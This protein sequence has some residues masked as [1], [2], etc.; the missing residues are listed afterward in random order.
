MTG[1]AALAPGTTEAPATS[2]ALAANEGGPAA[3]QPTYT[4][5]ATAIF[6]K[7]SGPAVW[8]ID[9]GG[10][11]LQLR[12]VKVN[13]YTDHKTVITAGL[14]DGDVVVLAG[15]HTVYVGQHVR[16]VRP[17]FDGEGDVEGPASAGAR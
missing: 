12:P 17:L 1:D 16:P 13:S 14:N 7:D 2:G 15:V 4:V 5:P 10:S 8:V 6:H 11:T 3:A 9:A